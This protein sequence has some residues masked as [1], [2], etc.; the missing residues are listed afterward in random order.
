MGDPFDDRPSL[1]YLAVLI[2]AGAA[3]VLVLVGWLAGRAGLPGC[4]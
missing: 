4:G 3:F 1:T 2:S